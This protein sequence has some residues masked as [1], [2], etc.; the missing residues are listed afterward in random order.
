MALTRREDVR[1]R[2]AHQRRS[3]MTELD[4]RW[5]NRCV[6][7][8]WNN[9]YVTHPIGCIPNTVAKNLFYPL[10]DNTHKLDM[11][12]EESFLTLKP[13]FHS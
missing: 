6:A 9:R 7:H 12:V 3:E 1:E 4:I 10:K 5:N 2:P 8:R 11:R 13:P